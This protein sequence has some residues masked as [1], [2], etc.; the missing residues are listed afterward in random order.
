MRTWKEVKRDLL[1]DPEFVKEVENLR[2][3]Y[4]LISFA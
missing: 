3:E 1:K 4:E 2:P